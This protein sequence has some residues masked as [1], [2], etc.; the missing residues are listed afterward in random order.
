MKFNS[1]W[2]KALVPL[3][4]AVALAGAWW[5]QRERSPGAMPG[6]AQ[7]PQVGKPGSGASGPP[8]VEVAQVETVP[9]VDEAQAV[10]TLRSRQSVV[11]RPEVA[12][13]VVEIA[14]ADGARVR[15]GQL[16]VRLDD[17]LPRA[18]LSQAQAQLSIAR[19]NH[20]RN[21]ELVAQNFVAQ[22]V[23]DESRASLQVAQAQ[24]QLAQAR[25]E[26]MH[27]VA[28]FDAA[29]GIRQVQVGD[30]VKDGAALVGLE[31]TSLLYVDFRLPERY[32]AQVRPGQGVQVQVDALA[33][34]TWQAQVQAV[35]PQIDENGRALLVRATLPPDPHTRLRPGLFA[36]VNVVLG[37]QDAAVVVPEEAIVPQG[38]RQT[39]FVLQREGSA[40]PR[41]Q[42]VEV[43]L[44]SRRDGKVQVVQGLQAGDTV[45]IAGQQRLQRDGMAVKVVD[46]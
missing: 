45:V 34:Q 18:E 3:A 46:L 9:W 19:A 16:L 29:V 26:R 21:E 44:G 31:D 15:K 40:P 17:T 30:Y 42:R 38:A 20:K 32:Q 22:R 33:A 36:R 12:G 41:V 23:L 43:V 2:R 11:L 37:R 5:V 1:K 6:S 14:F 39:V 13:R 24:V 27:I 35:E 8:S 7:A 10:G 25:L 4:L 28:P